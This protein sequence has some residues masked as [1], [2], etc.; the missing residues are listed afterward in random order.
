MHST[1]AALI[2]SQRGSGYQ[3]LIINDK[4]TLYN[5]TLHGEYIVHKYIVYK[6]IVRHLERSNCIT[7]KTGITNVLYVVE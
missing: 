1:V 3:T 7:L 5:H 4:I 2:T 6:C